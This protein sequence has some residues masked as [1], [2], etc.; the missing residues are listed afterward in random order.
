MT[1]AQARNVGH[2]RYHRRRSVLA[3]IDERTRDVRQGQM[4]RVTGQVDPI[5]LRVVA[6]ADL[7]G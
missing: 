7:P 1:G 2:E 3:R 4:G 6:D 5:Q